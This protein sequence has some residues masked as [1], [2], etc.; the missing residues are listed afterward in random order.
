MPPY[1]RQSEVG[2]R[3]GASTP[4]AATPPPSPFGPILHGPPLTALPTSVVEVWSK[5]SAPVEA[6]SYTKWGI[7]HGIFTPHFTKRPPPPL[8]THTSR[9]NSSHYSK[10]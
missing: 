1:N 4:G 10:M 8:K 3:G 9:N 7:F 6:V 2:S 5:F